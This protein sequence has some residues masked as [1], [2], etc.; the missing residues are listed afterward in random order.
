M[1]GEGPRLVHQ[2]VP[3]Q[4]YP[5]PGAA[6]QVNHGVL[7]QQGYNVKDDCYECSE[8]PRGILG[9]YAA[10]FKKAPAAMIIKTILVL[11]AIAA[12]IFITHKLTHWAQTTPDLRISNA[13]IGAAVCMGGYVVMLPFVIAP[14][15][16]MHK[17]T[18]H[19]RLDTMKFVAVAIVGAF[20]FGAWGLF[21]FGR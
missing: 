17:A 12:A 19:N 16:S 11:A 7:V 2:G 6:V 14:L 15:C 13:C 20:A 3:V 18:N 10:N 9:D 5:G 8:M 21:R 1:Q 4:Q